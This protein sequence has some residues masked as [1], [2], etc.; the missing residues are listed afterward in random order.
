[1]RTEVQINRLQRVI[2]WLMAGAPHTPLTPTVTLTGFHYGTWF[3]PE[4]DEN[5]GH[6]GTTGCIAGAA[7]LFHDPHDPSME[8]FP[9]VKARNLLGLT[10]YEA[11]ML[12]YPFD[13]ENDDVPEDVQNWDVEE[14]L[15]WTKHLAPEKIAVVLQHFQDTGNIDWNLAR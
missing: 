6:C 2:N 9:R 12:F 15:D 14:P 3:L 4:T 10:D 11:Q 5:T 1:M 8:G 13:L 7:I